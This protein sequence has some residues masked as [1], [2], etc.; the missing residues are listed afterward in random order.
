MMCEV[1]QRFAARLGLRPS[2]Q[3]AVEYVFARWDGLGL[4]PV[5]GEHIPPLVRLLHVANDASLFRSAAGPER[6]YAVLEERSGAAYV[7]GGA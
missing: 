3:E 1:A 7:P 5:T 2:I 4:P 6:A